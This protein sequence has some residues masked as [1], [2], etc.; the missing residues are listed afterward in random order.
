MRKLSR[1]LAITAFLV[2]VSASISPLSSVAAPRQQGTLSGRVTIGPW[3]PHETAGK[4]CP[5]PPDTYS[6][7]QLILQ[8]TVGGRRISIK[9]RPDGAFQ[10]KVDVGTYSVDLTKCTWLGCK[11][12]NL[13]R[14]VTIKPNLTT[15]LN[16]NIDTGIR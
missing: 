15:T 13:P 4:P 1:M 9:L 8:P 7:R 5:P 14:T 6:S 10:A 12:P 3:C 16:I 11:P 2:L